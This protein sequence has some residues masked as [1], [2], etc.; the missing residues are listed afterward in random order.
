MD[1]ALYFDFAEGIRNG[2]EG[3]EDITASTTVRYV[4]LEPKS[5]N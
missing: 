3:Q 2:L 5:R 4:G 1:N